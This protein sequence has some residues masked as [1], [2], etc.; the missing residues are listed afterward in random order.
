LYNLDDNPVL[1]KDLSTGASESFAYNM[2]G[3]LKMASGGRVVYSYDYTPNMKLKSKKANN[4]PLL[5]YSYDKDGKVV[6]LK[7]V[8]GSRIQYK[9]NLLGRI[10]EVWHKDKKEEEYG[11]NPDGTIASIRFANGIEASYSY[12]DDKNVTG[13]ITRDAEGRE[14]LNH[15]YVYDN[16]GNQ[17]E[18][19]ENGE[20][21]E[22]A[23]MLDL[24]S[25]K[26]K[27][28]FW[29]G[30]YAAAEEYAR[31]IG[32][33]TLEMTPGGSIF[34]GWDY[35]KVKYPKWGDNSPEDQRKLWI[36]LLESFA[37]QTTGEVTAVQKYEGYV[38]KEHEEKILI[39]RNAKIN[40]IKVN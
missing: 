3:T 5:E 36:A 26:D 15:R 7:A 28:V 29:S 25:P 9:Y 31:S 11:Y 30:N 12:D 21:E 14:I 34:N 33:T 20:F 2:D 27:A 16:N 38:W 40:R 8:T 37:E 18:R 23:E 17:V 1:R 39:A 32:G 35:V 4:K 10:Q 13:I 22:L 6:E 19:E 24:S